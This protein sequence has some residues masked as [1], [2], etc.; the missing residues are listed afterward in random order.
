ML[1]NCYINV[2]MSNRNVLIPCVV[3]YKII[4]SPYLSGNIMQRNIIQALN[5]VVMVMRKDM[6]I[7]LSIFA[8]KQNIQ[9]IAYIAI[10]SV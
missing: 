1:P 10:F 3:D 9:I 6:F 5:L 4:Q 8:R 2:L 7:S